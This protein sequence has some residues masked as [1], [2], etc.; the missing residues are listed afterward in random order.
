MRSDGDGRDA[1]GNHNDYAGSH[2]LY[3]DFVISL[4]N[5]DSYV[6]TSV[7][8]AATDSSAKNGHDDQ[9][10]LMFAHGEAGCSPFLC[11]DTA[12]GAEPQ[13]THV[14]ISLGDGSSVEAVSLWPQDLLLL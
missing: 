5:L 3:Q 7:Q 9:V 11:G 12:P 8:H 1:V 6:L 14:A 13:A 4:S 10:L 2:L